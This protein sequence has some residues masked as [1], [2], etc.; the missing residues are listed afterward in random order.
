MNDQY[1]IDNIDSLLFQFALQTVELSQKKNAINQQIKLCRADIAERRSHIETICRNTKKHELEIRVKQSTLIHNKEN[2]ESMK[3]VHSL[4]LQYE[5]TLKEELEKRK[6]SYSHDMEVYEERIES[7]KTI[8]QS[9]KEYY[10]QN[11]L[12]QKLLTLQAEKEEI[13]CRIKACNDRITMK[14]KELEHLIGPAVNSSST[15][16]LPDSVSGQQPITEPEKQLD[17][18]TEEDSDSSIDISSLNLNQTKILQNGHKTSVEANDEDIHQENKVQDS[19]ACSPSP[20]EASNELWSCQQLDGN[21]IF[22]SSE[23]RWPDV[24][25]T[26][27]QNQETGPEDQALEQQSTVSD[28][29][30]AVEEEM[31]ERVDIEEEQAPNKE[32]NEEFTAFPESSS[33]ETNPQSSPTK[34]TAVPS[35]PT[36]PFDF[37]PGGAPHRGTS[38]TKSPAFLFSLNPD[39]STPGFSG[40]EFGSSQE[41]DSSFVFT[42]SFFNEKKTTESSSCSEFLFGQPEQGE[43]FQFAFTSKSPQTTNKDNAGDDF[44]FS[45]NF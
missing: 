7:Y 32:D 36:F 34:M 28:I 19:T 20:E 3:A 29:Q 13:E 45:L 11:P 6:A 15:E 25:H 5:Q 33:Q 39:P 26:E 14:Q 44:P 22:I 16:K 43:D 12:A 9:Y 10:Y 31:E 38:D 42:G 21:R 23:Q 30:E 18:H 8:F 4:L 24:T 40:F 37:S 35:T 41:E 17:P 27:E 1:S 2:A